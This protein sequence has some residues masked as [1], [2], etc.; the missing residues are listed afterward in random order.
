MTLNISSFF[1]KLPV[2]ILGNFVKKFGFE[3]EE[4]K[5]G[6]EEFYLRLERLAHVKMKMEGR[7]ARLTFLPGL[8]G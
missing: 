6:K 2:H 3:R 1:C 4:R 7:E 8:E 5:D